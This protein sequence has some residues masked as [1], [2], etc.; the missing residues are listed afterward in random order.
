M[1]A[2]TKYLWDLD[3]LANPAPAFYEI[4]LTNWCN[5]N[6]LWCCAREARLKNPRDMD[7]VLVRHLIDK[8]VKLN[9]GVVFSG[10]GEPTLH[11]NFQDIIKHATKCLGV[12]LVSNGTNPAKI[13]EYLEVT[14]RHPNS[15]V[16]LSLNERPIDDKLRKL[17]EEYPSQI[18]ISIID[19]EADTPGV[20]YP[21]EELAPLAKFIRR[22]T[23]SDETPIKMSPRECVGRRFETVYEVDG[24]IAWCCHARGLKGKPPPFCF[25]DCRW[26]QVDFDDAWGENPWT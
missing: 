13:R 26:S 11:P 2:W 9:I 4:D 21:A 8:A 19:P 3:K 24:T 18:G 22:K 25:R 15:W 14:K 17:F 16:R 1:K 12:G 5:L 20:A 23:P 6:C 7:L 10:G